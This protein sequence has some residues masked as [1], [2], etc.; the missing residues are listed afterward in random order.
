MTRYAPLWQQA[1]SYA[2]SLDRSLLNTIWPSGGGVGAAVTA[3]AGTMT[4]SVAPGTVVVPLQAGQGCALC[5]WDAAEVP[6][7]LAAAPPSGQSRI[8]V[9]CVQVRDNALD[10]GGNNDFVFAVVTGTPAASN[11]ATPA[12]P[13]NA[14]AV[15]NVTVPGAAAN[16]NSAAIAAKVIP[17]G[18]FISEIWQVTSQAFPNTASQ[19]VWWDSPPPYPLGFPGNGNIFVCPVAG[20]YHVDAVVT[21]DRLN[22]YT[23]ASVY[24]NGS[25]YRRGPSLTTTQ[26]TYG[27]S[28]GALV[29]CTLVC[30]AGDTLQIQA[31]TAAAANTDAVNQQRTWATFAYLGP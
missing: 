28:P 25:M 30:A 17:L 12:T 11:P 9:I 2:A 21:W 23:L 6:P 15:A 10:S 7:V 4:V 29:S 1:G 24:K 14:Y 27:S 13:V 26:G 19:A 31:L 20:R 5:R 16:L 22:S 3:V 8:D 18:G